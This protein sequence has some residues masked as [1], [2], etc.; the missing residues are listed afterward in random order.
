[1][2]DKIKETLTL[3]VNLKVNIA[4]WTLIVFILIYILN[5][6]VDMIPFIGFIPQLRGVILGLKISA[7]V[8]LVL[9]AISLRYP[10]KPNCEQCKK[11]CKN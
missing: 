2:L 7:L 8:L 9:V 6:G 4:F 3:D 1:M 11:E 5:S 10:H